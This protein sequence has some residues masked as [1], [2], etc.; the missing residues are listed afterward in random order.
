M[1][2][3]YHPSVSERNQM[4]VNEA[5]KTI[6]RHCLKTMHPLPPWTKNN[7]LFPIY[8]DPVPCHQYQVCE[9]KCQS[10]P[11]PCTCK[12]ST[13]LKHVKKCNPSGWYFIY[14]NSIVFISF[15]KKC[16]TVRHEKMQ[17]LKKHKRVSMRYEQIVAC[18]QFLKTMH[19]L[20]PHPNPP[21]PI[22]FN[23]PTSIKCLKQN[24]TPSPYHAHANKS[25]TLK[26]VETLTPP[27]KNP[28]I[29]YT[30]IVFKL[31]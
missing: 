23:C 16:L 6:A 17:C 19:P 4:C 29:L 15:I 2:I 20:T 3:F 18:I 27:K 7:P 8:S 1:E 11:L 14:Q 9:T 25:T 26:H 28:H 13:A 12:K 5:W 21:L 30:K 31:K 22:I 10:L 24:V